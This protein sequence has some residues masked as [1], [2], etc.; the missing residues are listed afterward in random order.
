MA[1]AGATGR[2]PLARRPHDRCWPHRHPV[3]DRSGVRR[4]AGRSQRAACLCRRSAPGPRAPA[5]ERLHQ[6][7]R[8]STAPGRLRCPYQLQRRRPSSSYHG[9]TTCNGWMASGRGRRDNHALVRPG[10]GRGHTR[11][12]S[13]PPANRSWMGRIGLHSGCTRRVERIVGS[14]GHR[15]QHGHAPAAGRL[16][17]CRG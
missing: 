16:L 10:T 7:R 14:L 1:T 17:R 5:G 9:G 4:A 13:R 2:C 12:S 15:H 8:A 11:T 3:A 6:P